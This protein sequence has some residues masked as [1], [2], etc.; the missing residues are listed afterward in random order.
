MTKRLQL[1]VVILLGFSFACGDDDAPEDRDAAVDAA[2]ED[3]RITI[4][5]TQLPVT[6]SSYPFGAA[7]HNRV[8]M[9]LDEYG[10]VEH[11]FIVSGDA[12]TY[13]WPESGGVQE[14][15]EPAPYATR[16][17]VRRPK[18]GMKASGRVVV[19]LLNPTNRFDLEIGWALSH[20]YF[21]RS[22]DVWVGI[23]VKPI[24]V[25]AMKRFD[26][27]R[28][29]MLSWA[30]PLPETDE[31]NCEMVAADSTR[32]TENGLV[33]DIARQVAAFLRYSS[34]VLLGPYKVERVYAFGYSQTGGFLGTYINAI[35]PL[36]VKEFGKPLFDGYFIGTY[37]GMTAINQCA[38]APRGD[39][40]AELR[41]VG[42]PVM[43]ILTQ[44]DYILFGAGAR[45]NSA[46]LPDAFWHYEV[47]GAAHATPA[48]LDFAPAV[49]DIMKAGVTPPVTECEPM[50]GQKYPRSPFPL[51]KVFSA[52]WANLDRWVV[53][54][55]APPTA[56]PIE[57]AAMMTVLD[58]HGNAKGGLRTPAVDAPV[59]T[60]YGNA[61]ESVT[62]NL[63]C[64]L[65]GYEVPFEASKLQALY[66]SHDDYVAKVRASADAAVEGRF[67]L[68][69]DAD[70]I[71]SE[72]E[73]APVP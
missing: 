56:A 62:A 41:D 22:G 21:M 24:S 13:D 16:V 18:P 57:A 67:L 2:S 73:G 52:A 5:V 35:H 65:A 47:A 46:E 43:R 7:D 30:N 44:S 66:P 23:T 72:A 34:N 61:A 42:V 31:R 68:R 45:E 3:D 8:P 54:G 27:Q 12:K 19:E 49:A 70:A 6:T 53:D 51:G 20:D 10:Y 40:R 26:P 55:E 32:A 71:V 1:C 15:T 29:A 14:R 9:D 48:E 36:D 69:E 25:V 33:W 38:T 39:R 37:T 11:E 59:A 63:L 50:P 4:H 64:Y 58:D 28:Y 60:W 17:L